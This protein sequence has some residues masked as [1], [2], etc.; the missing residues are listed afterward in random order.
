MGDTKLA[1]YGKQLIELVKA[2]QTLSGSRTRLSGK[3]SVG[4]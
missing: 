2:Y 3:G 1:A 4:K